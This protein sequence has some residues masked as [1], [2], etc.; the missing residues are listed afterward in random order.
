VRLQLSPGPHTFTITWTPLDEN[1]DRHE[2]TALLDHLR[3]TRI[4]ACR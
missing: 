2:N 4:G 1:M 3:L